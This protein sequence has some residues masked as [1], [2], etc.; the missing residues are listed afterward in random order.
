L[1][2]DEFYVKEMIDMDVV[3][4]GVRREGGRAGGREGRSE[5]VCFFPRSGGREEGREG[6]K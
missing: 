2:E 4:V 5:C 3:M 1:E 6:G